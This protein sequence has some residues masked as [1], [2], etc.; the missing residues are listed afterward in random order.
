MS[1]MRMPVPPT[2]FAGMSARLAT[3][4]ALL[5]CILT[6]TASSTASSSRRARAHTHACDDASCYTSQHELTPP[7]TR[8]TDTRHRVV[9]SALPCT[10]RSH[11]SP[12]LRICMCVAAVRRRKARGGRAG[13]PIL[14]R[15]LLA[16]EQAST[17]IRRGSELRR[18]LPLQQDRPPA[19]AHSR[20]R[21]VALVTECVAVTLTRR[22]ECGVAPEGFLFTTN[23]PSSM[24]HGT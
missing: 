14:P 4:G 12:H 5:P 18:L 22:D 2:A 3:H 7:Q 21:T 20:L 17:P 19:H 8:A 16:S 23:A 11:Y 6:C 15:L 1:A 13:A 9:W 10:E 24:H